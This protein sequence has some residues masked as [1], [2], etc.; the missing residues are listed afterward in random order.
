M[1]HVGLGDTNIPSRWD[2]LF[3]FT[4]RFGATKMASRWD[5]VVGWAFRWGVPVGRVGVLGSRLDGWVCWASAGMYGALGVNGCGFFWGG[6]V[7]LS[8][9]LIQMIYKSQRSVCKGIYLVIYYS[10]FLQRTQID[11]R[12]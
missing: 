4:P 1:A 10:R 12:L 7:G 2:G 8:F 11:T 9:N 6:Q 5:A 3:H